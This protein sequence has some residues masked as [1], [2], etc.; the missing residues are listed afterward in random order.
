MLAEIYFLRLET[1]LR[2]TKGENPGKWIWFK[3]LLP[4]TL[5]NLFKT[6]HFER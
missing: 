3:L 5:R 4:R 2:T 1:E 6:M